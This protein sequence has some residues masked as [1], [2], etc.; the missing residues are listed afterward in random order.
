MSHQ[1]LCFQHRR[2]FCSSVNLPRYRLVAEHG[3]GLVD[4]IEPQGF[5]SLFQ[6]PDKPQSQTGAQGKFLKNLK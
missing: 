1:P 3:Q 4:F 5:F 2:L 6:F